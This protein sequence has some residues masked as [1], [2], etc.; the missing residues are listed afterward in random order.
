MVGQSHLSLSGRVGRSFHSTRLILKKQ[1]WLWPLIAAALLIVVG[2]LMHR[3]VDSSLRQNAAHQLETVLKADVAALDVWSRSQESL[4]SIAASQPKIAEPA[5]ELIQQAKKPDMTPAALA[6]APAAKQLREVLAPLIKRQG[7]SGYTVIDDTTRIVAAQQ[8]E[9]IGK[10]KL[11]GYMDFV[12]KVLAGEAIVSRPFPSAVILTD[13]HGQARSMVP[14]MF[15]AAPLRDAAG[16]IVGGLG[17]RIR[18][19]TDF[20]RI[21]NVARMGETGET[22]AFDKQGLMLSQSRFIEELKQLGLIPDQKFSTSVLSLELRDPGVNLRTHRAVTRRSELPLTAMAAAAVQGTTGV[23]VDSY[24]DY[25]GVETF[26]AWQWLPKYGIAVATEIDAWEAMLPGRALTRA[27]WALFALLILG[28]VAIFAFTVI[29]ARMQQTARRAALVAKKLG[30][31][32]LEEKIGEGGMGVVYRGHHAMLRRPTAIKLLN[33]E[34]TT[35]EAIRR[36]E[37]EV[38]ITSQLKHPNTIAIYDYGRTPEGVFYY[39]MEYLD[40]LNLETLVATSGPLP[41]GRVVHILK[42]LC[43]SLAE[44][45]ALGLI[46]RD[47][48]PA[49]IL[50]NDRGGVADFVKLLDFGLVKA[51]DR[52]ELQVTQAGSLLGT[53]LYM[54]PESIQD[55][56]NVDARSDLYSVGAVGYFLLTGSPPFRGPGL[57]ELCRQH[58]S[59]PPQPPAERLG[60]AVSPDLER[61]LLWCLAKDRNERP[62]NASELGEALAKCVVSGEWTVAEAATWWSHRSVA[63]TQDARSMPTAPKANMPTAAMPASAVASDEPDP[64]LQTAVWTGDATKS[65]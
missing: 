14:T 48:K 46:H 15:V 11:P 31:Y 30:Q 33:I 56:D 35:D 24:R 49:N 64:S 27:F 50:L 43:G 42:Q 13:E 51:V 55:P 34:K 22:Y 60:R 45:H 26:G 20:T 32:N 6:A 58:V 37:R 36:F 61:V 44:A 19:E 5:L 40:G 41:E 65:E 21:L 54:S 8:E 16:K 39:A 1:L 23:N 17:L 29:V 62:R 52:P 57:V 7:Y 38:S 47:I 2:Y 18:P 9:L 4:V 12:P 10:S 63:A 28:A 25:R 53:P 59:D 3:T